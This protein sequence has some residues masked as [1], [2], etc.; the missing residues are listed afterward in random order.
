MDAVTHLAPTVGIVAACDFLA[1]ARASYYRQR[2]VL[3][4][5]SSPPPEPTMPSERPTPAGP[6]RTTIPGPLSGSRAGHPAG[7]RPVPLLD[8][9]HVPHPSTAG[10]IRRAPRA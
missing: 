7:R 8:P 3:G 4:Q 10:R 2:P 5:S 6:P 9:H 1:V